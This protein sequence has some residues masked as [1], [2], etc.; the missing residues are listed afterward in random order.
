[1]DEVTHF[2]SRFHESCLS[3]VSLIDSIMFL[4][5]NNKDVQYSVKNLQSIL[6]KY[7][8]LMNELILKIDDVEKVKEI[9]NIL[10]DS[11][12]HLESDNFMQSKELLDIVAG[13]VS[14]LRKSLASS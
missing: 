11:M 4:N 6:M 1:M 7:S 2:L 10:Y 8:M 3:S 12:K 9:K 5:Y 13:K 14:T